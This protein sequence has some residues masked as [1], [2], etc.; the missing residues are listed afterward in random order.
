MITLRSKIGALLRADFSQIVSSYYLIFTSDFT[1]KNHN[2]IKL[3][4]ISLKKNE[5]K[6]LDKVI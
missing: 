6:H 2:I 4:N 1:A 5:K 3:S